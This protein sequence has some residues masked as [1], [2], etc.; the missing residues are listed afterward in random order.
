MG[1]EAPSRATYARAVPT[2]LYTA[3]VVCPM[4]G[5]PIADGGVLVCEDVI[6]AV[7]TRAELAPGADRTARMRGVLLPA[8]V[9]AHAHLEHADALHLARPGPLHVWLDA[10]AGL[11]SSW[12]ARRWERSAHRGVQRALRSGTTTVGDVVHRGPA[13]PA[14][15]RAGLRGDSFVAITDVDRTEQ[16][17]VVSALRRSLGLPAPGR[18]VGIAPL[19]PTAVGAGVLRA[20]VALAEETAAPLRIPAARSQTEVVALWGGEGPLAE[21]AREHGLAFEWLDGEGTQL[22]PVRYLAQL[23][24]LT[25]STTLAH[26][27]WVEDNEA[28][29][30]AE[31]GVAVVCCPRADALLQAGSAPL[32]R[33]AQAGVP[34][35]LGTDSAAAVPDLDVLAEAAPW[36]TLARERGVV[37]WPSAVGPIP[38][39]EA[40]VRLLTID[41]ARAMGWAGFAGILERGRRADLVVVDV[42]ATPETAYR[43]VVAH[44]AGRQILT[45]LGGVR[46]ARREDATTPWPTIDHELEPSPEAHPDP[47]PDLPPDAHPGPSLD[48]PCDGGSKR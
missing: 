43:D 38:L 21:R 28:R 16:D 27:I 30:L 44:G 32:E 31:L 33:Y 7:G 36:V 3:D 26:G 25:G 1:C 23:G 34:L 17:A 11:T 45:V 19:G 22:P 14:A 39:E 41:G 9:N 47:V 29:L 15:A 46:R 20:L 6:E 18:R 35:A 10:L 42:Q 4:T 37:F 2:T 8:L 24:A 13:V 5:P 48:A 40:A 12:D